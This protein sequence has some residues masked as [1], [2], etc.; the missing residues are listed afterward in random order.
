[1]SDHDEL[2][3]EERRDPATRR[4]I[5]ALK[6][7]VMILVKEAGE[8]GITVGELKRRLGIKPEEAPP[9]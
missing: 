2:T 7:V 4:R 5:E 6:T 8:K 9:Q 1:M 3:E